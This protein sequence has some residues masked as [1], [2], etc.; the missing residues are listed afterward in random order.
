MRCLIILCLISL[1]QLSAK[2]FVVGNLKNQ[3]GNQMFTIAATLALAWDHDAEAFFPD[4]KGKEGWNLSENYQKVFFRLN[5]ENPPRDVQAD[6]QEPIHSYRPIPFTPDM[7]ISGFFQSAKYFDHHRERIVELFQPSSE[8]LES[9]KKKHAEILNHPKTVAIH[10]RTYFREDP[11]RAF[12]H[13]CNRDYFE[14]AMAL[15][16]DEDTLFVVFSD[17]MWWC[18]FAFGNSNR[19]VVFIEDQ[20]YLHDFYLISLCKHQIISNSSFSWWAAYLNQNPEKIVIA[21]ANWMRSPRIEDCDIVPD[22]WIKVD[23]PTQ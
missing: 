3:L 23:W 5:A 14:R 7:Q 22:E 9:L 10:V 2:P 15:F 20:D 12:F 8:I 17:Q 11:R 19:Q 21:P 4:L 1:S 6:Y 16:P 13:L 18:K